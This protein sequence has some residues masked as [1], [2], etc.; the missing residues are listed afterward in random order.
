MIYEIS[1]F[2]VKLLYFFIDIWCILLVENAIN[3]YFL[4]QVQV[5][6]AIGVYVLVQVQYAIGVYV[7][8]QV[9][10]A[11]GVYILVSVQ[12]ATDFAFQFKVLFI[13]SLQIYC[14]VKCCCNEILWS[15]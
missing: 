1:A 2:F 8:V 6:Y 10:Y 7:L 11:N 3:N 12:Y 15:T 13:I 9:Q 14:N 5:Q 4:V